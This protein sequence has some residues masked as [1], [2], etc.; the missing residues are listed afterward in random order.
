LIGH[1]DLSRARDALWAKAEVRLEGKHGQTDYNGSLP[2]T[3]QDANPPENRYPI[4]IGKVETTFKNGQDPGVIA[5]D[6][7]AN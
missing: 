3:T 2:G 6:S 5:Y 1:F 7:T 4:L